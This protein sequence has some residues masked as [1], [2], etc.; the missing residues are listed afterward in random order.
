MPN[1][2]FFVTDREP[3]RALA[4]QSGAAC[5]GDFA[6]ALKA[7]ET[8]RFAILVFDFGSKDVSAIQVLDWLK[9]RPVTALIAATGVAPDKVSV[10]L[11]LGVQ[12]FLPSDPQALAKNLTELLSDG[13]DMKALT[14][15]GQHQDAWVGR[16]PLIRDALVCAKTYAASGLSFAVFGEVGT[17]RR[18]LMRLAKTAAKET[19][20]SGDEPDAVSRWA[21]LAQPATLFIT[22]PAELPLAY[23]SVVASTLATGLHRLIYLSPVSLSVL[24]AGDR[25]QEDL[26]VYLSARTIKLPPLR[27][28]SDDLV[29]LAEAFLPSGYAFAADAWEALKVYPWPGNVGELK[30]L[31][32]KLVQL[33][34]G[35]IRARSLPAAILEKGFYRA[36]DARE[37]LGDLSYAD[38][39]RVAL[40]EF[41]RRYLDE[42]LVQADHNLTVAA[43]KAGMDRSNFK[44]IL[45]KFGKLGAE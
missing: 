21:S 11:R 16:H 18:T 37:T 44:K 13:C 34:A 6:S 30:D 8:G 5:A 12:K 19:W 2:I 1:T 23:Q 14:H 33:P 36:D 41:H 45:R 28:R 43:E 4:S 17:G 35:S 3:L 38:A 20:I 25:L 22:D 15:A 40:E 42:V 26:A 32:A 39:K 9:A 7:L 24:V 27:E 29:L 31:V 10:A